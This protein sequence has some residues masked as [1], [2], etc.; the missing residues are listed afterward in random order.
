[1]LTQ[2][3]LFCW[4]DLFIVLT[5]VE[6]EFKDDE[7]DII[8]NYV[9]NGG[10]LLLMSNHEPFHRIDNQLSSRFGIKLQGGYWSG[11]RMRTTSIQNDDL[12]THPIILGKKQDKKI[13]EIV[14]DTCCQVISDNSDI[15]LLPDPRD[16]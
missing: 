5:R 9:R 15:P 6:K 2:I 4:Y 12:G 16:C 1:M 7:L 13:S 8:E 11:V 10:R 3:H 14:T